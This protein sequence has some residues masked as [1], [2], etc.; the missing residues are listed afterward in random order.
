MI[1]A[2]H[3]ISDSNIG[4]AGHHLL[5]LPGGGGMFNMEVALPKG[6]ALVDQLTERGIVCAEIPHLAERSFSIRSVFAL[7]KLI[8][9]K[10]PLI[11]HTHAA[12]SGRVA[13]RICGK[14]VVY[15]RH[16]FIE[17]MGGREAK[18]KLPRSAARWLNNYFCDAAIAVSPAAR[19][20]LL[21]SGIDEK[22][23]RI[24]FNG[25][26]PVKAYSDNQRAAL[27]KRYGIAEDAFVLALIGRLADIK[28]HDYVLDAVKGLNGLTVIFAGEGPERARLEKRIAEEHF[29]HVKLLG[30][31]EQIDEILNIMD[32]QVNASFG[33]EATSLALLQG[34]S[35]GKPAVVTDSGGNPHVIEDG[36]NGLVVPQKDSAALREAVLR[37]MNDKTLNARLRE[38]ALRRYHEKFTAD[39]M[40][41]KTQALYKELVND[42]A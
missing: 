35:L 1:N 17:N 32:A 20:N 11:V 15:T 21:Q 16:T 30:F 5:D 19:G 14:K 36:L 23:I 34:M 27:R 9:E 25:S 6:S 24:I 2:L 38:G 26:R 4:G 18:R 3:I 42:E 41:M 28:G 31:I 40:A 7:I 12:F 8:R 29:P 39:E 37:L 13:G 10:K 33:A 22:K